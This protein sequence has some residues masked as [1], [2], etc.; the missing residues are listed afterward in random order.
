MQPIAG[1]VTG[2]QLVENGHIQ[3]TITAVTVPGTGAVGQHIGTLR[4]L[5]SEAPVLGSIVEL[6]L[7]VVA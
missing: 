7:R 2:H 4:V 3:V 5:A 1:Q 6:S